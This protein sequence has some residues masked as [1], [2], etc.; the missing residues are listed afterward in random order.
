[1]GDKKLK[2]EWT[3]RIDAMRSFTRQSIRLNDRE[4]FSK[5]IRRFAGYYTYQMQDRRT[6]VFRVACESIAKLTLNKGRQ[7]I[8]VAPR[9]LQAMFDY[10]VRGKVQIAADSAAQVCLAIVKHIPDSSKDVIL[11]CII[12]NAKDKKYD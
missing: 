11:D 2:P 7:L 6:Q 5:R 8:K 10:G 1:M 3:E 12:E 9:L 4:K